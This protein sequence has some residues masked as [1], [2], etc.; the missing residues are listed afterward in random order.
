MSRRRRMG[1]DTPGIPQI[2]RPADHPQAVDEPH[3]RR[4]GTPGHIESHQPPAPAHLLPGQLMLGM[5]FKK[6]IPHPLDPRMLGEPPGHLLG[7]IAVTL[8]AHR[9][10]FQ[11]LREHPAAERRKRRP[12]LP[13]E[14]ANIPDNLTGTE[15]RPAEHPPLTIDELGGRMDHDIRPEIHRLLQPRRS[16]TV[17]HQKKRPRIPGNIRHRRHIDQLQP[18]IR[19]RLGKEQPR[20]PPNSPLPGRGIIRRH[21]SRFDPPAGESS[22]E[23]TESGTEHRPGTHDMVPR[24]NQP[25][26]RSEH[27]RHTRSRTDTVLGPLHR[28]ELLHEL[29]H[30]RIAVAGIHRPILIPGKNI[31]PL[32]GAV[33]HET[34]RKIEGHTVLPLTAPFNLGTNRPGVE[35]RA[36]QIELVPAIPAHTLASSS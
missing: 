15:N 13:G 18:R 14:S 9:K 35:T 32:L 23:H 11:T 4:L 8:H 31:P 20:V 33:E 3:R 28:T 21:E 16:E 5:T 1:G 10:S 25:R 12:G 27:R 26:D 24:R 34:G 17:I 2:G 19:R 36:F 22:R 29:I 6:R 7:V 30:T